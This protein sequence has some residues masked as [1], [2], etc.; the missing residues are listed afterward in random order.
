M[1]RNLRN[2]LLDK[3]IIIATILINL[4]SAIIT[5][6][7]YLLVGVISKWWDKHI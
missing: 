7:T 1:L 4:T 3:G 2:W 5:V 6:T